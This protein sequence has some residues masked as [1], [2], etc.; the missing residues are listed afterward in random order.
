MGMPPQ[1]GSPGPTE[2][3]RK[4]SVPPFPTCDHPPPRDSKYLQRK[5][6]ARQ[7]SR[8]P[9]LSTRV[10]WSAFIGRSPLLQGNHFPMQ[11][12]YASG[13]RGRQYHPLNTSPSPK[14]QGLGG[15]LPL[16]SHRPFNCTPISL[17]LSP[18]TRFLTRGMFHLPPGGILW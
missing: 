18:R 3:R 10:L 16:P 1:L 7:A 17:S 11:R 2:S 9:G 14:D 15:L 5:K 12:S 4:G 6:L 8:P 13:T